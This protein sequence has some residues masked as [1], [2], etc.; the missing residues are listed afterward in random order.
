[1]NAP[2]N[3]G[4]GKHSDVVSRRRLLWLAGG[5]GL[6]ATV[7]SCSNKTAADPA[8]GPTENPSPAS[9]SNHMAGPTETGQPTMAPPGPTISAS[10]AA[11]ASA[12]LLCRDAW[13]ARPARPGGKPHT[14]NRLTIHH[15]AVVLGANSNAPNRFRQ[16]QRY[17][18]DQ[19][20]WVDI[21]YHIGIDRDGHIYEL[22]DPNIAG[23]TATE[24]DTTGHFLVFC[25]GDFDKEPVSDALLYGAAV[26]CAWAAQTFHIPTSTLAG[27]RDFAQTSCPGANLYAHISSGDLRS[28]ID[29]L[30]DA[31]GVNLQRFCGPEAVAAVAAIE[32]GS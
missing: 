17:H 24:Y 8:S 26:A 29:M 11:A 4:P 32:A 27:H 21:A 10:P 31:G 13:Q 7:G 3:G 19:L 6:A 16:D 14:P 2:A 5:V 15:S 9:P 18:Q 12:Q 28:R 30:L 20:G 1:M 23:D 22:R 25:E